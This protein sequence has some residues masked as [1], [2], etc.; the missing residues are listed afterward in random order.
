VSVEVDGYLGVGSGGVVFAEWSGRALLD[1]SEF[2]DREVAFRDEDGVR[3]VMPGSDDHL[4]LPGASHVRRSSPDAHRNQVVMRD[5]SK[6][7]G[8]RDFEMVKY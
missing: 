3:G 4:R 2:G 1:C 8:L 7:V 6:A 5:A